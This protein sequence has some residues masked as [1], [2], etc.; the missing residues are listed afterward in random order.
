MKIY[1]HTGSMNFDQ[2]TPLIWSGDGY[3][4]YYTLLCVFRQKIS[5]WI[6]TA[7]DKDERST[8]DI[9]P[10]PICQPDSF[11]LLNVH[12][13]TQTWRKSNI[14]NILIHLM[15][16]CDLYKSFITLI[17]LIRQQRS[18]KKN[19]NFNKWVDWI[20]LPTRCC[21][22]WSRIISAILYGFV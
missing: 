8:R 10:V 22:T 17:R 9:R 13:E 21:R 5:Q 6:R 1:V 2:N 19:D 15:V 7:L 14:T 4:L 16:I 18:K 11:I 20:S 3:F 12:T